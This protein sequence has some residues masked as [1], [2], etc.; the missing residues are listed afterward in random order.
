MFNVP[1]VVQRPG[2]DLAD[3]GYPWSYSLAAVSVVASV[4]ASGLLAAAQAFLWSTTSSA[5][6]SVT[7]SSPNVWILEMC[8]DEILPSLL[9]SVKP[10]L[11][12][13]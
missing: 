3:H 2:S 11:N 1:C 4:S 7:L 12:H 9:K 8:A 6:E 13:L 5:T 10:Y